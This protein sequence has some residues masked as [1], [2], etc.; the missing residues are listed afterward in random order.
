MEI[1]RERENDLKNEQLG[2]SETDIII[3]IIIGVK[4]HFFLTLL[5]INTI[6][7]SKI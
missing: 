3:I 5:G 7:R 2:N 4:K 1:Y 6:N